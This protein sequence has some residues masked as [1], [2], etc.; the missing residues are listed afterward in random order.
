MEYNTTAKHL[1]GQ[2]AHGVQRI[3]YSMPSESDGSMETL[4]NI[5]C[6]DNKHTA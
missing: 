5:N 2:F 3:P 6:V 1:C 4:Q